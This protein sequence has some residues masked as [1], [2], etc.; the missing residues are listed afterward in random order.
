MACRHR[1]HR[2]TPQE[3]AAFHLLA[4]NEQIA[5]GIVA[6]YVKN[7]ECITVNAEDQENREENPTASGIAEDQENIKLII[8]ININEHQ[9]EVI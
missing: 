1:N 3:R 6:N 4:E 5:N 7:V 8:Y 9:K 2:T